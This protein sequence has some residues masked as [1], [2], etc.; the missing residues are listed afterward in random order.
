MKT[1]AERTDP[2]CGVKVGLVDDGIF[3]KMDGSTYY[4]CAQACKDQFLA[5]PR[6]YLKTHKPKRKGFWQ[7]YLDRLNKT[8]G[9]KPPSCCQ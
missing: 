6:K 8:T 5:D 2:V 3:A 1:Q 9:G 7:R 4:F